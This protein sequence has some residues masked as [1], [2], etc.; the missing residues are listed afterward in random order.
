MRRIVAIL[1]A[2]LAAAA[3]AR[4]EPAPVKKAVEDWLRV[5][6]K[7]LPGQASYTVGAIDANNALPPC[8]AFEVGQAPGARP[9]GRT[10]VVVRCLSEPGWQMF[11]PVH[12]KVTADYLVAARPLAQGQTIAES[13][14]GVAHG[15][16]S[17]LPAGVVTDARQAVGRVVSMTI[18]AGRPVRNDLLRQVFVVQQG[19]NVKV[20]SKGP[21][22]QVANDGK[23]LN[24]AAEGQVAQARMANGQVI[25]GIARSGGQIEVGY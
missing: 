1:L 13:D 3:L 24:N 2:C 6:I 22:F 25:S 8:T 16:L 9:W 18:A 20:V 4:Q 5:Q 10:T 23:A 12:I 17:D 21:G 14:L 11:V 19:Q 15:D 7:G